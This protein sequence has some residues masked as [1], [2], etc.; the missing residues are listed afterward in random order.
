MCLPDWKL[1]QEV[2]LLDK[3]LYLYQT[4]RATSSKSHQFGTVARSTA[5]TGCSAPDSDAVITVCPPARALLQPPSPSW[6][7]QTGMLWK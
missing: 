3:Q 7:K 6:N 2:L 1:L 4:Q 5:R